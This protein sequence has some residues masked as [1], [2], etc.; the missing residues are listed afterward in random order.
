MSQEPLSTK[1]SGIIHTLSASEAE[2]VDER[3][4]P[5]KLGRLYRRV[6]VAGYDKEART[7]TMAVSS[8]TP[9]DRW[10][11]QEILSHEKGAIR[12]DRLEGG[13]SLLFNHDYDAL[14]G[15][16]I[17]FEVGKQIRVT[18]K[19]GPSDLS[20]E[21]E[22]EV[23]ADVLVDVS[24]GY[25]VYEWEITEDKNGVRTYLAVDWEILEVSLVTVPADPTVGVGRA[26]KDAIAVKVRSF[27]T[28]RSSAESEDPDD[29]DDDE[30]DDDEGERSQAADPA[31]IS[32]T[33]NPNPEP[34]RTVTMADEV[35]EV[36]ETPAQLEEKRV[37]GIKALRVQYPDQLTEEQERHAIALEVPLGKLK[38]RVA[39]Q[40][41]SSSKRSDVPTIAEE[42]FG[43][44][45]PKERSQFSLRDA[46]VAAFNEN[47]PASARIAA[48]TKLVQDVSTELRKLA[49]ERGIENL[50]GGLIIPSA[51]SRS[52]F[53]QRTVASGGNA[54]TY[55]NFTD[56]AAEPIE[57]LRSRLFLIALGATF[58]TGLKGKIQIPRQ[59]AAA[60]S[61]WVAEGSAGTASDPALDDIVMQPNRLTMI[62]S[63]YR[64]FLAQSRLAVDSFL[65]AD[66]AAV[67]AR[68]LNTASI[69]GSGVA[70]IPT[71]LLNRSGLAAVLAGTSRNAS[72]GVVTAGAGGVPMTYVDW[73][74]ME[75]SIST[76]NGDIGTLRS[77]TTPKV[78][79][80]GR[81]TPKTGATN[82]EFVWPDSKVGANGLQ[83]G[84]LGYD[85][86]CTSNSALTGFT[87][88]SVNNLHAAIMGVWDQ[89]LIGDW[90]LSELIVD[91]VT[92]AASAKV[93]I[94]EHGF[95]DTNIRHIESF[96]A[97]TS[98]L[99]Q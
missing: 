36:K 57:L 96:V 7:V 14:L 27:I 6:R 58:M 24:I 75:A 67:L 69:A 54:G 89:L 62:N 47:A 99:P 98:A 78:R 9:V 79:A 23:E 32:E 50:G 15:R 87:A 48:D 90:G 68:S 12:T 80:A 81:S 20:L 41:I 71:G 43:S 28:A 30:G 34:K 72:T 3:G 2:N 55:T 91:N 10:Y 1:Y 53:A 65:A 70:P 85:A 59:N 8:E 64:D 86:L 44:M 18:C 31:P 49:G 35:V 5:K 21:K 19:F 33:P 97:C 76:S 51:S 38:E 37:A 92:N 74:N 11:G 22:R 84:P 39:D 26:A 25:V 52:A 63:Y 95:Y 73:N 77:L 40:L 60:S 83:T 16:S 45:S 46:Y 93:I 42:L 13:V 4:I 88:N 94:T 56:V 17:E 66:R 82:G 29:D 61:N